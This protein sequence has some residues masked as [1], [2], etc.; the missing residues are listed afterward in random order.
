MGPLPPGLDLARHAA[1]QRAAREAEILD[2]AVVPALMATALQL[3]HVESTGYR[4]YL[5]RLRAAAGNPDDPIECMLL[6]QLT[7]AHFRI[8]QLHGG[9]GQSTGIEAQKILCAAAA[10][11]LGEFRRTALAIRVYRAGIPEGKA[12]TKMKIHKLAQ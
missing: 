3:D 11:L 4:V 8:A 9:A 1:A 7:M 10:R 2:R 12:E 5:D 6:E